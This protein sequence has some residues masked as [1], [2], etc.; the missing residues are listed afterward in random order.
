[1]PTLPD[2]QGGSWDLVFSHES[3]THLG[4]RQISRGFLK[5]NTENIYISPGLLE[6]NPE[7][8]FMQVY[9]SISLSFTMK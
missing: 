7:N 4:L 5:D 3:L 2:S 6:D 8:N 1:M 9:L